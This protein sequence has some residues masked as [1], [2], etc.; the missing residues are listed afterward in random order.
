MG[1]QVASTWGAA[2]AGGH[3]FYSIVCLANLYRHSFWSVATFGWLRACK[4][5]GPAVLC[6]AGASSTTGAAGRM[7]RHGGARCCGCIGGVSATGQQRRHPVSCPAWP[8][9]TVLTSG[10]AC[11][12]TKL[13]DQHLLTRFLLTRARGHPVFVCAWPGLYERHWR[14]SCARKRENR[15]AEAS[16]ELT[17][18]S[19]APR[20]WV[21]WI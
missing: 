4:I 15:G 9:W 20:L 7:L 19:G 16:F 5:A 18:C 14:A 11:M 3:L 1:A 13:A 2:G 17:R 21:F 6:R 8:I 12:L 10:H